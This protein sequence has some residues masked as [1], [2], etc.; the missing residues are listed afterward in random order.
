MLSRC[1]WS[2]ISD[3]ASYNGKEAV[4]TQMTLE[5]ILEVLSLTEKEAE[6]LLPLSEIV[7]MTNRL[8]EE[9]G[10]TWVEQHAHLL[11]DQWLHIQSM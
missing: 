10:E 8:A 9:K 2:S 5:H 3:K 1:L 11:R 4:T 6:G 7:A